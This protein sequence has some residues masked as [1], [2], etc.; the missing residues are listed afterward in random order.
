MHN[1]LRRALAAHSIPED[2]KLFFV[3]EDDATSL[4]TLLASGEATLVLFETLAA[5]SRAVEAGVD[6]GALNLGHVPAGPHRTPICPA[7]HLAPSDFVL[8]DRLKA[9]GVSIDVRTLPDDGTLDLWPLAPSSSAESSEEGAAAIESGGFLPPPAD[10][11][12]SSGSARVGEPEMPRRVES[13][14][15]VV[16][17]RGL[18]LRVAHML[19][20]LVS[21]FRSSVLLGRD[22][23]FVNAKSLLGLTTL[24]AARGVKLS[25]IA[26]GVDASKAVAEIERFFSSDFEVSA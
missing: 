23:R 12:V 26:E 13:S 15:T 24:G 18:H 21:R 2:V 20:Q 11:P 9:R 8:I 4:G 7:V 1:P 19:A 3:R 14:V 5:V 10:V 17:E 22:G 6:I 25:V 16:N